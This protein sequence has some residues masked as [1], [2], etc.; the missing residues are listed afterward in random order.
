MECVIGCYS[1]YVIKI[2]EDVIDI[3]REIIRIEI[4]KIEFILW[5]EV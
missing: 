1:G 4:D 3:R 2:L 5:N